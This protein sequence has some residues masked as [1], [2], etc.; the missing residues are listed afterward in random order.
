MTFVPENVKTWRAENQDDVIKILTNFA[1]DL[2]TYLIDRYFDFS[3]EIH[4]FDSPLTSWIKDMTSSLT[5]ELWKNNS[6]TLVS[7][8]LKLMMVFYRDQPF[9]D[10][11]DAPWV[12]SI[13]FYL[14]HST[15]F[16][17][18]HHLFPDQERHVPES[19]LK[20]LDFHITHVMGGDKNT[21]SHVEKLILKL[22][23]WFRFTQRFLPEKIEP[24]TAKEEPETVKVK[25]EPGCDAEHPIV[26][27]SGCDSDSDEMES[28]NPVK[29]EQ[30]QKPVLLATDSDFEDDDIEHIEQ[31]GEKSYSILLADSDSEDEVSDVDDENT[32]PGMDVVLNVGMGAHEPFP[33]V[34]TPQKIT[35]ATTSTIVKS[36]L[37]FGGKKEMPMQKTRH[38]KKIFWKK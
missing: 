9:E 17:L 30:K 35:L 21:D 27:D 15:H 16:M 19:V 11:W 12:R 23:W 37:T 5:P 6:S 13:A 24:E 31:P 29:S 7:D 10:A 3:D 1:T 18:E 33:H 14:V 26:I 25:V 8:L 38:F 2:R 4:P 34:P 32:K 28:F 36:H 20:M 22:L